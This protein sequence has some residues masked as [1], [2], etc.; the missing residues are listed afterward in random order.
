[1]FR[2]FIYWYLRFIA[3]KTCDK[4][5]ECDGCPYWVDYMYIR[6]CSVLHLQNSIFIFDECRKGDKHGF[7]E[8]DD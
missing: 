1:M 8:S 7:E 2:K 4:H 5:P 3:R 6:D